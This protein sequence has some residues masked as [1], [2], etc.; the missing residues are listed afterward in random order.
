MHFSAMFVSA[1]QKMCGTCA[2][3]RQ[4]PPIRA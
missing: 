1:A 4:L 2:K 3:K